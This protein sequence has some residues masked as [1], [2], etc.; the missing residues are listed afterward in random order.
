[1][2]TS[3]SAGGPSRRDILKV[4]AAVAGGV[5]LG[6][7]SPAAAVQSARTLVGA[8]R[9]D[10]YT[11]KD[12]RIGMGANRMLSPAEYRFRLPFYSTI[13]VA[14]P[15]LLDQNFDTGTTGSAP[16]GWTVSAG[17]G[18]SVS[19]VDGPDRPGKTVLLHD[20]STAGGMATMSRTFAAQTRAVTVEWDWKE[21]TAGGWARMLVTGGSTTIVD[22]ATQQVAG[23]KQLAYRTTS[24][25]W[26][27]IQTV[28]DNT[29]YSIKVIVD[30]A[31]PEGATPWVDIFVDGVR[32]AYHVPF[33][34]AAT[35]L[36]Q[37]TFQT[38][39]T[40]T[41]DVYVDNVNVEVTES[42]DVDATSQAIMDQEIQ[43][44]KAA[45]IDYWAFD[46]YPTQPMTQSRDLYLS[47]TYKSLVNWCA[48]L[49]GNFG[50]GADFDA[51][52]TV[53]VAR[54]AESNYQ[55]VLGTR[56]LVYI[57]AGATADRVTAIR[58]KAAQ[59]GL[60]DPYV[61]VTGWTAQTATDL[62]TSVGADAVSRYAAVP[63]ST[64]VPY[65]TLTA[66]ESALWP[67]YATAAGQVVPTV[68]TGWDPRDRHDYPAPWGPQPDT[69]YLQDD[70]YWAQQATPTQIA[71]H[72][73]DA[74]TWTKTNLPN[75]PANTVL[76]YA[77][78]ENLEGGWICP[79]L[80]ETNNPD[81]VWRLDAIATVNR[82][83]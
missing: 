7:A 46:Y 17:T 43:Y 26:Q 55:K 31:P 30:P 66:G 5:A 16:A 53:L 58:T 27:P 61:V 12:W 40:L 54:M 51:N 37:V 45:G 69:T 68:T 10:A 70:D 6:P 4:A 71:T 77:W 81:T 57:I 62:M 48:I 44:A 38:N 33:L 36:D 79:T 35:V 49:D 23:G 63:S 29:W 8:I 1:M 28:A 13:T 25:A 65:S 3:A 22:I 67:A 32:G 59:A 47:S 14:A 64:A 52:L 76:I 19:V 60:G 42:V 72:L 20:A 82:T 9:W 78:N 2:P 56:P 24:G 34:A 41:T 50:Y 15:V 73:A 80:D 21:T 75:A 11:G 74:I 39:P 83:A 18:S